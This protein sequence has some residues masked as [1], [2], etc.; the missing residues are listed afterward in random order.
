MIELDETLPSGK[1]KKISTITEALCK[2]C[3]TC[4]ADCPKN[5]IEMKHF[6]DKQLMAQVEAAL[7]ENPEQ[8]ILGIVCNWCTYGGADNAGVSRMQYPSNLRLIRVMCTGRV[9]KKFVQRAFELGAGMVL[10]SGCHEGDCH[11]ISG[12]RHMAKRE[13]PIRRWMEKTGIED[14]RFRLEW[15]S[16][17]EGNKFQKVVQ[18]MAKALKDL[19]PPPK[20]ATTTP[21]EVKAED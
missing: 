3:G 7:E 15:I 8:K 2:G 11:Y 18:E 9:A 6:T 20:I 13:N 14:Q 5:A 12:N 19:G 1:P 10:V 21:E 16:A 4:A 17:S